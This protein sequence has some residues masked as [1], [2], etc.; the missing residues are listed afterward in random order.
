ML[1]GQFAPEN[2]FSVTPFHFSIWGARVDYS[3]A[4]PCDCYN[5]FALE[6]RE[7]LAVTTGIKF[8]GN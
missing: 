4:S 7:D 8:E 6:Y 2:I 1:R 3:A 5:S